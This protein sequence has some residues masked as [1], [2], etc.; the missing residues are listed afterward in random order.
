[1]LTLPI[2]DVI[3]KNVEILMKERLTCNSVY[4]T[5]IKL[6]G[7]ILYVVGGNYHLGVR[8]LQVLAVRFQTPGRL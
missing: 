1:M 3:I 7:G 2:Y 5:S 6:I 8:A 4:Q